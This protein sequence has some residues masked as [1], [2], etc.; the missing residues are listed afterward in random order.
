[1]ASILSINTTFRLLSLKF[2][3]G[4][5]EGKVWTCWINSRF[6]YL[7]VNPEPLVRDHNV[8]CKKLTR[9]SGNDATV[10]RKLYYLS[11]SPKG[12]NMP[13][14]FK[15]PRKARKPVRVGK[16]LD[17]APCAAIASEITD[18]CRAVSVL[19]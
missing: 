9:I 2:F 5:L 1:M 18:A 16:S 6:D 7:R 3:V 4:I 10:T 15:M 11:Q 14:P 17:R 12:D 19:L 8:K 13:E